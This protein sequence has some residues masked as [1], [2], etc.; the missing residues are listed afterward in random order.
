MLIGTATETLVE[1]LPPRPVDA[2]ELAT[3]QLPEAIWERGVT[4][5]AGNFRLLAP[6]IVPNKNGKGT[7]IAGYYHAIP[8]N[9]YIIISSDSSNLRFPLRAELSAMTEALKTRLMIENPE[10]RTGRLA[11]IMLLDR[12]RSVALPIAPILAAVLLWAAYNAIRAI[13]RLLDY[14]RTPALATF[15][16]GTSDVDAIAAAIDGELANDLLWTIENGRNELYLTPN[17][18]AVYWKHYN[19]NQRNSEAEFIAASDVVGI[20]ARRGWVWT[21]VY[22]EV[23]AG[24]RHKI[25]DDHIEVATLMAHLKQRMPWAMV[26]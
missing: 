5:G 23:R 24:K 26:E 12:S 2:A 18:I 3:M 15:A 13:R 22:I 10:L 4:I 17:W 11:N 9:P 14:R 20:L 19:G 1:L 21:Y 6:H 25:A 8:G 7:R 16:G